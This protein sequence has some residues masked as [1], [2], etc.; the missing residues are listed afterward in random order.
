MSELV[1][2]STPLLVVLSGP[3][4][5]GKDAVLTRLRARLSTCHFTVTVTTR[6]RR[7]GEREGVDYFF[8]SP[9]RFQEMMANRE[10][11]EHAQVYGNWY[12][13]PREQVRQA[14]SRGQD[15][16]IKADVQ[17]AATIKKIVPQAVFIF[18]APAG[19]QELEFRLRQRHTESLEALARRLAV[20]TEEMKQ[21]KMFDYVVVN[22]D[23][24]MNQAISQIEAI[25][26]AEK[27]RVQ[28]RAIKINV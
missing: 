1:N 7:P 16:M 23:R 5:V 25:I 27:C 24:Q 20:A 18:L 15:V 21:L 19:L 2:T 28:P 13:V 11:L 17:G 4:G 6:P 14:F 22:A 26:T 9:E 8:I 12:G 10:L 3:S